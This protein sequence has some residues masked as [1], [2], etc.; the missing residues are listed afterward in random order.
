MEVSSIYYNYPYTCPLWLITDTLTENGSFK[1]GY[2]LL[3]SARIVS[4]FTYTLFTFNFATIRTNVGCLA[5]FLTTFREYS[6]HKSDEKN[7]TYNVLKI[8]WIWTSYDHLY[9]FFSLAKHCYKITLESEAL[10]Y[11]KAKCL[12]KFRFVCRT[13]LPLHSKLELFILTC[14]LVNQVNYSIV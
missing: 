4:L 1:S 6:Y 8:H 9:F 13:F 14:V 7:K 12:S 10:V 3:T 2:L 11:K 5:L